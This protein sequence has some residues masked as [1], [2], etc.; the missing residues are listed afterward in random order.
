MGLSTCVLSHVAADRVRGSDLHCMYTYTVRIS[1][2]MYTIPYIYYWHLLYTPSNQIETM[3]RHNIQL[4]P[5]SLP[6]PVFIFHLS[7][8]WLSLSLSL[9]L[10]PS[11]S[12][13]HSCIFISLRLSLLPLYHSLIYMIAIDAEVRIR[14]AYQTSPSSRVCSVSPEPEPVL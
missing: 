5:R 9:S 3:L 11:L 2:C 13:S 8:T 12:H 14:S 6:L 4:H 10:S 1:Y 7:P